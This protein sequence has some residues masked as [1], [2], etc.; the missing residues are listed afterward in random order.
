MTERVFARRVFS[1]NLLF[2]CS[3]HAARYEVSVR[4]LFRYEEGSD[5]EMFRT[6]TSGEEVPVP[7]SAAIRTPG[8]S[9]T[10]CRRA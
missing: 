4:M 5:G 2:R 8:A 6:G 7:S 3:R 1:S 10:L 9:Y